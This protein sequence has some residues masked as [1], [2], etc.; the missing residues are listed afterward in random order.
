[1]FSAPYYTI[2]NVY[3]TDIY[4]ANTQCGARSNGDTN[5]NP[6][7]TTL[8]DGGGSISTA[9]NGD[10]DGCGTKESTI[11]SN[12]VSPHNNNGKI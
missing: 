9:T 4:T 3:I 12:C 1:M 10:L 6:T 11:M 2:R 8:S 7:S 5:I